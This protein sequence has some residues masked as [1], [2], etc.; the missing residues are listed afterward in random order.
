MAERI[1][2]L[3]QVAGGG[4]SAPFFPAFGGLRTF[5]LL[6]FFAVTGGGANTGLNGFSGPGL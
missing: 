2:R 6:A 1:G 3:N 4:A 5:A